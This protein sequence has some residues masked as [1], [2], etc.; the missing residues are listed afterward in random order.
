MLQRLF[1]SVSFLDKAIDG[2]IIA[3]YC[4]SVLANL[5]QILCR[6]VFLFLKLVFKTE[7]SHTSC[8]GLW[9]RFMDFGYREV[10]QSQKKT[11][12]N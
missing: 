9:L 2:N 10:F 8:T 5:R 6:Y 7:I 12:L 3:N 11:Q 4:I 1:S